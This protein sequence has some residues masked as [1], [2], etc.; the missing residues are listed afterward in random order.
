MAS[1]P[2]NVGG[3]GGGKQKQ[4]LW[5]QPHVLIK[6]NIVDLLAFIN[7]ICNWKKAEDSQSVSYHLHF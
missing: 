7:F 2:Q 5:F 6:L 3:G 4:S 1:I